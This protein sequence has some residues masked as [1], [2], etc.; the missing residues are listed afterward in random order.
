M[1]IDR[2]AGSDKDKEKKPPLEPPADNLGPVRA[3]LATPKEVPQRSDVAPQADAA[4]P[5]KTLLGRSFNDISRN[6]FNADEAL[7]D[8]P[9]GL[10]KAEKRYAR[11]LGEAKNIDKDAVDR[12]DKELKKQ[13]AENKNLSQ[14][15]RDEK[16]QELKDLDF[17]RKAVGIVEGNWGLAL[18]RCGTDAD[19]NRGNEHLKNALIANPEFQNDPNFRAHYNSA[20]ADH[21]AGQR[22]TSPLPAAEAPA[23]SGAPAR[24]DAAPTQAETPEQRATRLDAKRAAAIKREEER[25]NQVLHEI[26]DVYAAQ[27]KSAGLPPTPEVAPPVRAE[28]DQP[29]EQV[30]PAA[31]AQTPQSTAMA[32]MA[33]SDQLLTGIQTFVQEKAKTATTDD[34][35]KARR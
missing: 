34:Q 10:A 18:I 28:A 33:L 1:S 23:P 12:L 6:L 26:D 11:A 30:A 2:A 16:Q 7:D 31:D 32:A 3:E 29:K 19:G 22:G 21:Q 13:L 25:H 35:R 8:T 9:A 4:E 15:D 5:L 27:R 20:I 17:L 24:P 14:K